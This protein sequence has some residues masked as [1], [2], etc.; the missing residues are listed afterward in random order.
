LLDVEDVEAVV[1]QELADATRRRGGYL[2]ADAVA[3][4]LGEAWQASER[5]DPGRGVPFRAYLKRTIKLRSVDFLRAQLGRSRW[6][7]SDGRVHERE[8]RQPL[9]LDGPAGGPSDD[10][11]G[12][13]L[14]GSGLDDAACRLADELRVLHQR[15]RRPCGRNRDV[16]EWAA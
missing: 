3:W 13:T 1:R 8:R 9:S 4:L 2:R 12:D 16:D 11:L 10:R 6:T 5:F 7:F 15:S 14:P